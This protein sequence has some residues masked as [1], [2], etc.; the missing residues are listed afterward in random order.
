MCNYLVS[1][2][3][4]RREKNKKNMNVSS[5]LVIF[6]PHIAQLLVVFY[7]VTS[8]P[9]CVRRKRDALLLKVRSVVSNIYVKT[10]H[11]QLKA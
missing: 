6:H 11:H 2:G 10:S 9:A 4:I 8:I 5:L 7:N 1:A 3:V